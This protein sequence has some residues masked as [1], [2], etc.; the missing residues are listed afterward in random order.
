MNITL[1]AS[2]E[3]PTLYGQKFTMYIFG[4]KKSLDNDERI[5]AVVLAKGDFSK[6]GKEADALP[7]PVVR[8]HSQCRT[9]DVF[10]SLLC[11]CGPQLHTAQEMIG[12]AR[13][14]LLI[15]LI[16][17]HEGRSIG[18]T[19]KTMAYALQRQGYDTY[20]ANR[21][22]GFPDDA[23]DFS[24]AIDILKHF[25]CKRVR[26]ITNNP[27]KVTVLEKAGITVTERVPLVIPTTAFNKRYIEAKRALKGHFFP[28]EFVKDDRTMAT[29]LDTV[30]CPH[31]KSVKRRH[32]IVASHA[33]KRVVKKKA[34]AK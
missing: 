33:K 11:D 25:R 15:Y 17:K 16:Y 4:D 20:E 5:A 18:L 22:L 30:A 2:A 6:K 21:M 10:S 23:R 24:A 27:D 3:L 29:L 32:A 8:M 34:A 14:G 19:Y 26:L 12:K 13:R 7:P 31:P 9:G 1:L 28:A